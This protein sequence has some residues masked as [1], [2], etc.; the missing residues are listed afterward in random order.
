MGHIHLQRYFSIAKPFYEKD[1]GLTAE[2][3]IE[4]IELSIKHYNSALALQ[5]NDGHAL[6]TKVKHISN[7][8]ILFLTNL[9]SSHIFIFHTGQGLNCNRSQE[10]S[11]RSLR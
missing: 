4:Y 6:W 1:Y 3:K 8:F 5:P 10:R 7:H 2:E 11:R 9:T